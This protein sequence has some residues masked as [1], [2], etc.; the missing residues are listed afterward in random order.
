MDA[1]SFVL[2]VKSSQ[3]RSAQLKE[4]IYHGGSGNENMQ[5]SSIDD[6]PQ[7]CKVVLFY[8][9]GPQII[10]FCR[11]VL[12]SG[13][14]EYRIDNKTVTFTQYLKELEVENILVKARNF[15]VFQGDVEAVA[16][17]SPKDLTLL[18]EQISG[19]FLQKRHINST[20]A[21]SS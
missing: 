18:I 11:S 3:L 9:K 21:P 4:L 6:A 14:S 10:Q 1:I 17:Q 7:S 13:A 5:E 12:D 16:S 8:Q 20:I 2:G 15:L 19:Y